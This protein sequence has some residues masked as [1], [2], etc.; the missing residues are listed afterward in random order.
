MGE[1]GEYC[2]RPNSTTA[3]RSNLLHAL[4]SGQNKRDK[5]DHKQQSIP[6]SCKADARKASILSLTTVGASYASIARTM[7]SLICSGKAQEVHVCFDTY[8]ENSIKGSE[9]QQRGAVDT[10]YKITG[11]DQ[12]IRQNGKNLLTNG[13]FK[14]ELA[15]FFLVEWRKSN[16]WEA[17]KE[18]RL[19]VSETDTLIAFHTAKL[20]K[21]D[22]VVRASDTDVL[23]ILISAIGR[24]I[25]GERSLPKIIMDCGVGDSRSYINV[26]NIADILEERCYVN[27][28]TN[29]LRFE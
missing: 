20:S 1:S 11:P 28:F 16:Y 22:V 7:L 2:N 5:V 8:V 15:K 18:K 4:E 13:T 10:A 26:T 12:K 24:Q 27:L 14:N 29:F 21:E 19:F 3:H 6:R 9:R 23:V 25:Q 17:L